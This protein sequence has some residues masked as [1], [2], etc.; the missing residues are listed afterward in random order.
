MTNNVLVGVKDIGQRLFGGY[1][2]LLRIPH[3]ARF[4]VGSVIAC[5]PFPMVGMTITISVQHY[6]GNYSLA[7]ALTAVQAIAL[8]VTSPVLGKLV[9]KFGQRQVSIPTII[10]W[11]VA[12][13]ALVSCITARV[14]SW[15]LFCIVPFMAAIPPWG[16]MS[17]QRWTTLLK[18]MRK[19]E[20]RA[21]L[22]GVFD[23]CMWVIGNPLAS[24]LAVISGL[25]AFSFTGM[26]VVIG[27]LMFLTELTTEPKSQTQLAREAGMTRKEYRE[28][29]AARSK[30]L[31]AEAAVEYA[32]NKARAEGK[33]AAE[34]QAAMEKAE[35][36]V[37]A[38]RKESIWGPGLIAVCVTWF[39]LGAFQSAA[40][41]SIVAFATEAHMKQFTGF[42]FA[43]FSFSSLIGALVY[44]AKKLD[45][46]TVEAFLLLSCGGE[47]WNRFVH[48][49]QASVGDHDHLPV[50]RRLPGSDVGE[51][52]P[53][54]AAPGSAHTIYRRHGLDG[55]D[56]FDRRFD[57]FRDRRTVHRPHGLAGRFHCGDGVGV[58]VAGDRHAWIQA[59][60]RIHRTADA[61][62]RE[63]VNRITEPAIPGNVRQPQKGASESQ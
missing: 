59:D 37:K 10:V 43:C 45:D 29:E 23:E 49:R 36:E 1:A 58:D 25:L 55:R 32:R 30:A 21:V 38:G 19:N 54:D 56:E 28:R 40:G 22:S 57:R 35:A 4:S 7:G 62:Q 44:G 2:E 63:C 27:A 8:A 31:Q 34:V 5:M 17:R 15:I 61:Y 41:I 18:G 33:T 52:Q 13:V 20:P 14:P 9:D 6:Y 11:M 39:G 3:T 46:S 12:A 47:S 48:V 50:H 42:V 53:A 51:R 16:A 24:T 60:Q 26:C